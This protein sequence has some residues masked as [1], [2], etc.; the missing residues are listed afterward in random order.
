MNKLVLHIA[1]M[2]MV[3]VVEAQDKK[4]VC[5]PTDVATQIAFQGK[6]FSL[7][8]TNKCLHLVRLEKKDSWS[9]R[10]H[11]SDSIGGAEGVRA[12]SCN[13]PLSVS[14]GIPAVWSDADRTL[15]IYSTKQKDTFKCEVAP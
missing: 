14:V 1:L 8:V 2:L 6:L 7:Q 4:Y 3:G 12:T 9:W 5:A 10:V 11:T 15:H 13:D